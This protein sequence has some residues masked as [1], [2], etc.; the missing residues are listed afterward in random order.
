LAIFTLSID[1]SGKK[2]PLS[3]ITYYFVA[4]YLQKTQEA[5]KQIVKCAI[6]TLFRDLEQKSCKR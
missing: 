5:E 6:T 4:K 2:T 3:E 1:A